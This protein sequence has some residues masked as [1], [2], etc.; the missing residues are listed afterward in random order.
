M[1]IFIVLKVS[2]SYNA[3][4]QCGGG[5]GSCHEIKQRQSLTLT[6][7]AKISKRTIQHSIE[8]DEFIGLF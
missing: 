2:K 5:S 3:D 8:S 7:S 6:L 1:I 4:P